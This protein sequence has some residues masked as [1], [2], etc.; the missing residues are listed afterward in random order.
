MN[1]Q[2]QLAEICV[3]PAPNAAGSRT[4]PM[5][6][7]HELPTDHV[8]IQCNY[9]KAEGSSV[10]QN[11]PDLYKRT[12]DVINAH[13]AS[14]HAVSLLFVRPFMSLIHCH[15][16]PVSCKAIYSELALRV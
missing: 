15:P 16:H 11:R 13:E 6:Y 8:G 14:P 9:C 12:V 1:A 5:Q 3:F 2:V 10:V 4:L 7:V